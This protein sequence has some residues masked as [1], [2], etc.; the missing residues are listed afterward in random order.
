MAIIEDTP[1]V[2]AGKSRPEHGIGLFLYENL[3]HS[4]QVLRMV[5]QVRIMY[6]G[7]ITSRVFQSRYNGSAFAEVFLVSEEDPFHPGSRPELLF[8]PETLDD[9]WSAVFRTIIHYDDLN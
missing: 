5:F 6:D 1:C 3:D 7:Y 4:Q 8:H 9:S 2:A